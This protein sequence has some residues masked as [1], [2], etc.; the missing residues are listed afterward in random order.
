MNQDLKV[1]YNLVEIKRGGGEPRIESNVQFTKE[2][3]EWGSGE[4]SSGRL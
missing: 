4:G 3:G 1:L 2:T